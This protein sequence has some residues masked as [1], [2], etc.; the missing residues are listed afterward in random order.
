MNTRSVQAFIPSEKSGEE[1]E[2]GEV[3]PW[4]TTAWIAARESPSAPAL[5]SGGGEGLGRRECIGARFVDGIGGLGWRQ[6]RPGLPNEGHRIDQRAVERSREEAAN[7]APMRRRSARRGALECLEQAVPLGLTGS[8]AAA[9]MYRARRD[10]GTARRESQGI[11]RGDR[12]HERCHLR[13]PAT[14][15]FP[16]TTRRRSSIRHAI[17]TARES[18]VRIRM[19]MEGV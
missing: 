7:G 13:R 5:Q 9:S 16:L 1:L 8:D 4:S 12:A 14:P 6:Q 15:F 17:P 2:R 11:G 3:A 19:K 10:I 18:D